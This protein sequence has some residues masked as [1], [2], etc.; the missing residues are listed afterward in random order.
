[1]VLLQF[2]ILLAVVLLLV[3]SINHDNRMEKME[4]FMSKI[5]KS[6][7]GVEQHTGLAQDPLYSGNYDGLVADSMIEDTETIEEE[8]EEATEE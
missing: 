4:R 6:I 7:Q 8:P 5:V 3:R 1:M 2:A